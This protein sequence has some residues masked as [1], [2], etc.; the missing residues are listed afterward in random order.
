MRS[1]IS[2]SRLF[3]C[4]IMARRRRESSKCA[5]ACSTKAHLLLTGKFVEPRSVGEEVQH[6]QP[7]CFVFQLFLRLDSVEHFVAFTPSCSF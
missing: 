3:E 4:S 1:Q 7:D 2:G 6:L 5:E